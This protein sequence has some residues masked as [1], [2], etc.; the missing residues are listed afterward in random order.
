MTAPPLLGWRVLVP[1]PTGQEHALCAALA[2]L[3]A[4]SAAIPALSI[5]V[6][7]GSAR[8]LAQ[9]QVVAIKACHQLIFVSA[10]AVRH[11]VALAHELGED[12]T[13]WPPC[14][15]V[16][17]ATATALAAEGISALS[18]LVGASGRALAQRPELQQ[19]DGQRLMIIRGSGGRR[20]LGDTLSSRGAELS[21]CEVYQRGCP[22]SSA[23]P[24]RRC[25]RT[26]RLNAAIATS[27]AMLDNLLMLA[28]AEVSTL[29]ALPL[30][31]PGQRL[32]ERSRAAGF[33]QVA[34]APNAAAESLVSALAEVFI[35]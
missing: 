25:L 23:M 6:L 32:L 9:A 19:L 26:G 2:T 14:H 21:Y 16:G 13:A 30:C 31:V 24:L 15:A 34:A 33:Q 22:K 4:E 17:P 5:D 1:R 12:I 10:N 35:P 20:W 3:G 28:G 11:A 7:I 27:A 29:R 8:R 18:P